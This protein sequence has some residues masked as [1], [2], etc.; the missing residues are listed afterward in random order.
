[1]KTLT[2]TLEELSE[3]MELAGPPEGF[4]ID[5][6]GIPPETIQRWADE[7][8]SRR[9]YHLALKEGMTEFI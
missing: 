6:S 7:E 3:D 5:Y 2:N 8:E 1:M 4:E 9:L